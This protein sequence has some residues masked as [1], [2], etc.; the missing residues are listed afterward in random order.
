MSAL[1]TSRVP[2]RRRPISNASA[3]R[4]VAGSPFTPGPPP[5]V[6]VGG[7]PSE[8]SVFRAALLSKAVTLSSTDA[9]ASR[10]TPIALWPSF[11]AAYGTAPLDRFASS[12]PVAALGGRSSLAPPFF[13]PPSLAALAPLPL[14]AAAGSTSIPAAE[15]GI[16]N[17]ERSR[18]PSRS[19][20][21]EIRSR[22]ST[23]MRGSRSPS[24][25]RCGRG[26]LLDGLSVP[27][28]CCERRPSL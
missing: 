20:S 7:T 25:A 18:E 10:S 12:S 6:T 13:L 22:S 14:T 24:P 27:E 16:L 19:L 1:E 11:H 17:A 5:C 9:F 4:V 3:S 23:G 15:P 26:T 28:G 2:L 8:G 21:C